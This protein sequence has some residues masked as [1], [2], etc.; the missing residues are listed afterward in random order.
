MNV[1]SPKVVAELLQKYKLAPLKNLGQNFLTDG[2]I[3][4]KIA[5][6]ALPEGSLALEVGMGLGALTR[7]LA[8]RAQKL[9]AVE[10]DRGF[11]NAAAETLAGLDNVSVIEADILEAD[12]AAI[13]GEYFSGRRFYV[14]GN[15]PYYITAPVIMRF[16]ESGLPIAALTAMV[17]KEVAQKLT[18]KPG[19]SGYGAITAACAYFG[20]PEYLFDVSKNCFYPKPKVD[21]A[22]FRILTDDA[23]KTPY[24]YYSRVV[25][26]AFSMRRKTLF[27]NLKPLF[28]E[29]TAQI[30]EECGIN[31]SARAQDIA[32]EGF[33]R[34]AKELS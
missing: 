13:C 34:I 21:S 25:K 7:E 28:G 14:C 15:L 33:L 24:E 1:C 27:N 10:I 17:Q 9:A 20:T 26:A 32:P 8:E 18:A 31:P 19:D 16:L 11:I 4:R 2:N 6:A 29:N 23:E 12:I 22:V 3:A 5:N 30:L